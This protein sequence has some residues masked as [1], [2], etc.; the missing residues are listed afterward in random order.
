MTQGDDPEKAV[1]AQFPDAQKMANNAWVFRSELSSKELSE[2]LYPMEEGESQVYHMVCRFDAYWGYH[3]K[4][5][6]ESISKS[7]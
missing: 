6:W 5:L 2:L 3:N 4:A 7:S 1:R